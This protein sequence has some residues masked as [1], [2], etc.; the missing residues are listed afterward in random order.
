MGL[1]GTIRDVPIGQW[2]RGFGGGSG[3]DIIS[4]GEL[5]LPTCTYISACEGTRGDKLDS[6]TGQ[7]ERHSV[8]ALNFR[9][10]GQTRALIPSA[11]NNATSTRLGV[12]RGNTLTPD[13]SPKFGNW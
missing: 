1:D 3:D 5:R 2:F 8:V 13:P 10:E 12:A 6:D 4:G 9:H 7:P 11:F